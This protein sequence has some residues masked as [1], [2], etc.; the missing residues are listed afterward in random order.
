MGG[1]SK[2]FR[3][4]TATTA[5]TVGVANH[6]P[7]VLGQTHDLSMEE[8]REDLAFFSQ[9][10]QRVHVNPFHSITPAAFHAAVAD[11]ERKLPR[12]EDHE[13]VVELARIVAMIGD[14]HTRLWL[15]PNERN[16]F[17]QLPIYLYE[18]G[19]S[20]G[21][22]A[23]D[24]RY[25]R[26]AGGTVESIGGVPAPE[27]L[28]RVNALAQRDNDMTVR[29]I[30][31]RYLSVPE[32]LHAVG[33]SEAVDRATFV[34]RGRD[35][36]RR[37][38]ELEAVDASRLPSLQ[39]RPIDPAVE[40][41]EIPLTVARTRGPGRDPLW[42]T[43]PD[44][45]HW[46]RY[47]T[48]TRTLYVQLN[49]I[50]N[51]RDQSMREFFADVFAIS[52]SLPVDKFV[53]DLRFN[54]GGNNMLN[55]SVIR[56]LIKHEALNQRGKF[57]CIIGRHTF[58][59]ASHLVSKL[60]L[61]T[62]VIFVGEPT[63]GSPN[64]Y[65]D[66]P[67]LPLPN[68]GLRPSASGMYWQNTLPSPFEDRQWT[69]PEIAAPPSLDFL[70]A[71]RDPAM[72]AIL[73]YRR[74]PDLTELLTASLE[75]GSVDAALTVYR[76]WKADPANRWVDSQPHLAR[77]GRALL[78]DDRAEDALA[79]LRF[80]TVEHPASPDAFDTLGDGYRE[81][82]RYDEAESAYRTA[83]SMEPRLFGPRIGLWRMNRL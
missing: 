3:L 32:V 28:R 48:G 51:G 8:W 34:I 52:D 38:V 73:A 4:L 17:H 14:G 39:N 15:T 36:G 24:A 41:S 78:R 46:Y 23:I 11:L 83:L 40:K 26:E 81:L 82:E 70:M 80:N 42:L 58:S 64:H 53:I 21:V 66:A 19:D 75:T 77:V 74:R 27:A 47:L 20:L 30:A 35:G 7:V 18:F 45:Y 79:L 29:S 12:L 22:V 56:G 44:E 55:E 54:G 43:A 25:A 13:V 9:E 63:G 59:A 68:S 49:A 60:E 10:L 16:G 69:P 1:G 71:N 6:M 62:D 5:L 31:P 65:G 37:S 72:E 57:F 76:G 67:W 61:H 50:A 33:L 2:I